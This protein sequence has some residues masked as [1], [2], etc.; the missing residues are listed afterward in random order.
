MASSNNFAN[1]ITGVTNRS[2]QHHRGTLS[3]FGSDITSLTQTTPLQKS[4][5]QPLHMT[6]LIPSELK[7]LSQDLAEAFTNLKE[8]EVFFI[9]KVTS[10]STFWVTASPD[11]QLARLR[12]GLC[13]KDFHVTLGDEGQASRNEEKGPLALGSDQVSDAWGEMVLRCLVEHWRVL[14]V[15]S[16]GSKEFQS[17]LVDFSMTLL[18]LALETSELCSSTRQKLLLH[19]SMI[20]F[21]RKNFPESFSDGV[22]A[23]LIRDDVEALVRCGDAALRM[24]SFGVALRAYWRVLS[25]AEDGS[26]VEKHAWDAL[27]RIWRKGWAS[28]EIMGEGTSL[29]DDLQAVIPLPHECIQAYRDRR[30]DLLEPN[31]ITRGLPVESRDRFS[32]DPEFLRRIQ[33]SGTEA[34]RLPRFFSWI[35]PFLIAGMSTPKSALD[36]MALKELGVGIVITLT[37]EEPLPESWFTDAKVTHHFWPTK[38]YHPPYISHADRFLHLLIR[39]V[40]RPDQSTREAVLVHC[41][42]G[43]GRAGSLLAVYLVRF[44]LSVPPSPCD[45]CGHVS[46]DTSPLWCLD[47]DC[48]YGSHPVMTAS[49]AIELLR[50]LRPGSI[51][52]AKQERFVAEYASEVYRRVGV[53]KR[54]VE[55]DEEEGE[56]LGLVV[57]GNGSCEPQ[58]LVLCG[59]PASGKSWFAAQLAT[60][61]KGKWTRLCQDDMEGSRDA[62]E[63]AV[64]STCSG[65]HRI[66]LD[67]CNPTSEMRRHLIHL[68]GRS[69]SIGIVHFDAPQERCTERAKRRL[70][71]PTLSPHTAVSAIKSFAGMMEAPSLKK[72]RVD[73][74]YRVTSFTGSRD[75]LR[76]FGVE[77]ED[78][79]FRFPR[80][81]HLCDLGGATRDDLVLSDTEALAMIQPPRGEGRRRVTVEEKVDGANVG[82]RLTRT[83]KGGW[84]VICQNRSHDGITASTH[85][86]FSKLAS[87]IHRHR[88]VLDRVLRSGTNGGHV[89]MF[90]EWMQARHSVRYDL[91]EDLF[92]AFDIYDVAER[93]FFSRER[94]WRVL[95]GTGMCCA[96]RVEVMLGG[97]ARDA[98]EALLA[99]LQERSKF[100]SLERREGVVVRVDEGEWLLDKAKIVRSDF[101]AGNRHWSKNTVE[102]NTVVSGRS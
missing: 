78:G 55:G 101:I 16:E 39:A 31:S 15:A 14:W 76:R 87:W 12:L 54:S 67:R 48:C 6:L 62:F 20:Q 17:R 53:G 37:E 93:R 63:G 58:V 18:R 73:V 46:S 91:L 102:L 75:L 79:F 5:T 4:S 22:E 99:T 7:S 60:R 90:G 19:R 77:L 40:H 38:N 70:N 2:I 21:K 23:L 68:T 88:E 28:L 27:R 94:F 10:P 47:P 11:L 97:D 84:E 42:G 32:L 33:R 69:G 98:K 92:V 34:Y 66:I 44:G 29:H 13:W 81:R 100:S 49:D 9:G 56:G 74:I 24:E 61:S 3:L 51:E 95:E 35:V 80:T 25:V 52:T 45:A 96:P 41:G 30:F 71:H 64:S 65:N 82:F 43:K 36:V 72:D 1:N 8:S 89:V 50:T 83:S 59:L 85:P 86:Q 57:D 26:T